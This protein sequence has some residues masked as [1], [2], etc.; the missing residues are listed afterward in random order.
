LT[1]LLDTDTCIRYLNG[2]S[3]RAGGVSS[4]SNRKMSL[5]SPPPRC[6]EKLSLSAAATQRNSLCWHF[7]KGWTFP[8]SRAAEPLVVVKA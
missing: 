5:F 6:A 2:R 8:H 3:P 4:R 7:R 1:Y